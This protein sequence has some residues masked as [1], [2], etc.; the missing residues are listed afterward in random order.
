[1]AGS[2]L[3]SYAVRPGVTFPDWAA[4]T[5][6]QARAA[7]LAIFEAIGAERTWR[8][9]TPAEDAVRTALLRLY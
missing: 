7:L 8:D 1:M 2:R 6:P 3:P 4:V 9:Y 5:S